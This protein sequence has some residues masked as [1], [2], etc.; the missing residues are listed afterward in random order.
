LT[1]GAAGAA[2]RF[3]IT[4]EVDGLY[5]GFL[6]TLDAQVTNSL[7]VPVR[8]DEVS[9]VVTRSSRDCPA[10]T[11]SITTAKT[12][13]HLAPAETGRVP[14]AMSMRADAGDECQGATFTLRFSGTSLAQDR[15]PRSLAFTGAGTTSLVVL[16]LVV[17]GIGFAFVRSTREADG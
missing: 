6:G 7:V 5:P 16:A 12:S 14:L 4:G 2:D 8:V 1:A 15:P 10:A 13:L 3:T 11:L 17:L 9:G